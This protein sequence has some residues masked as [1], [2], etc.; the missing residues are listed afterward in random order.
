MNWT[1]VGRMS[2]AGQS[3]QLQKLELLQGQ[4]WALDRPDTQLLTAILGWACFEEVEWGGVY[5]LPSP[6]H[7]TVQCIKLLNGKQPVY[8]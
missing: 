2:S 7:S 5:F 3:L 6:F 4:I 1:L 8:A